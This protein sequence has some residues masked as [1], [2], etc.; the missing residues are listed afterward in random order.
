MAGETLLFGL[1]FYPLSE[2]WPYA[3]GV[4]V[5]L[6]LA[7]TV[8]LFRSES[9]PGELGPKHLSLTL[10]ALFGIMLM[11]CGTAIGDEN[12]S[13]TITSLGLTIT[14]NGLHIAIIGLALFITP[15]LKLIIEK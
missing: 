6:F 5:I 15:V 8:A 2:N 4:G 7:T 10:I 12:I 11:A 9:P 3:L 1:L 14:I 13:M